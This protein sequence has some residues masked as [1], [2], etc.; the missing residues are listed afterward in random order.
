MMNPLIAHETLA[1]LELLENACLT[2]AQKG[3]DGIEADEQRCSEWIEWSL[4]LVTPL[5]TKIGYDKAASLAYKAY[6]E[7]RK[8]RDVLLDEKVLEPHELDQILDP[9]SML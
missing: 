6:K 3:I 2:L 1:S 8:I 9:K 7:H 4:A 5:A